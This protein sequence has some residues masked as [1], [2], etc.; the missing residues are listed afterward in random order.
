MDAATLRFAALI[1]AFAPQ[2]NLVGVPYADG[3]TVVVYAKGDRSGP[4]WHVGRVDLRRR[5]ITF[6]G[7]EA[8]LEHPR[9]WVR[10]SGE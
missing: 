9:V 3:E 1:V 4:Q 7:G 5:R 6:K 10:R 8:R 2:V